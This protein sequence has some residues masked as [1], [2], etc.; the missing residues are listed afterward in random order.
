MSDD[1]MTGLR[2]RGEKIDRLLVAFGVTPIAS[3]V[4][5]HAAKP[6][7]CDANTMKPNG[8]DP[9]NGGNVVRHT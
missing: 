9:I 3:I 5:A 4:S 8:F 6:A 7:M 1:L 2:L